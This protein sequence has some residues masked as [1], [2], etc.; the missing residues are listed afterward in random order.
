MLVFVD[1]IG[2]G[3]NYKDSSGPSWL[4][5]NMPLSVIRGEGFL[6]SSVGS[7]RAASCFIYHVER[8]EYLSA[9]RL[10]DTRVSPLDTLIVVTCDQVAIR[11]PNVLDAMWQRH[12]GALRRLEHT[13]MPARERAALVRFAQ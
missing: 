1:F 5:P 7:E 13:G 8:G 6:D 4:H 2:V 3:G 11:E 9:S 12:G 10:T